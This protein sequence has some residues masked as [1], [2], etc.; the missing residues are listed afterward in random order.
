MKD[1]NNKR[2][3]ITHDGYLKVY[4]LQKRLIYGYDCILID[5]A[6]DLTPGKN[7][8]LSLFSDLE[9]QL[10]SLNPPY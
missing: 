1:F 2:L 3:P 9:F 6:Q 10:S 5:E 4:Q 7:I 8:F